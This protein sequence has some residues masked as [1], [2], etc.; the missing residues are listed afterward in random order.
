M[1]AHVHKPSKNNGRVWLATSLVPS[2]FIDSNL[3]IRL[4]MDGSR[5]IVGLERKFFRLELRS[6]RSRMTNVTTVPPSIRYSRALSLSLSLSLLRPLP[7][8]VGRTHLGGVVTS[9]CRITNHRT[10]V[11]IAVSVPARSSGAGLFWVSK[12][13]TARLS[14]NRAN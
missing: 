10:S 5:S 12:K 13:I 1:R 3:R 2:W 11:T 8:L 7:H 9:A 6:W 4:S 14:G